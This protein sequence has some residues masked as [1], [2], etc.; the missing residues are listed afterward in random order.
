MRDYVWGPSINNREPG[1]QL[2]NVTANV[3][4]RQFMDLIEFEIMSLSFLRDHQ[5]NFFSLLVVRSN[6]AISSSETM[7]DVVTSHLRAR[8]EEKKS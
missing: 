8:R 2:V 5:L 6:G 1:N 4:S 3:E 7:N